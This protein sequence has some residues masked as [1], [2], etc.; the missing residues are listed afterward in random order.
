MQGWCGRQGAYGPK[1]EVRSSRVGDGA[2]VLFCTLNAD[3][4]AEVHKGDVVHDLF[5]S[6][7]FRLGSTDRRLDKGTHDQAELK[8]GVPFASGVFANGGA[9]RRRG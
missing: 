5:A 4:R 6:K 7:P 8:D 9:L 3:R 1:L 2:R